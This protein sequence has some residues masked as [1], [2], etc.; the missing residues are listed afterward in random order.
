MSPIHIKFFT[1]LPP[2]ACNLT[3]WIHYKFVPSDF[4]LAITMSHQSLDASWMPAAPIYN[5]PNNFMPLI[6]YDLAQSF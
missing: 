6:L 1:A 4:N 3:S 2:N 5:L